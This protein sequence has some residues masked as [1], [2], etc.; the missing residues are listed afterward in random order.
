M[1][2]I[3]ASSAQEQYGGVEGTRTQTMRGVESPAQFQNYFTSPIKIPK[4][5]EIAVESIKIRRDA[6]VDIESQ[7]LFY[8]Y[9]G[10]LQST[11]LIQPGTGQIN[12]FNESRLEMPIPIR[13]SPGTYNTE[14]WL[15]EI[16]SKLNIS[17][18]NPEIFGTYSVAVAPDPTSGKIVGTKISIDQ[19]GDGAGSDIVA[20][21]VGDTMIDQY[22]KSPWNVT[23][24]YTEGT[25]WTAINF[26]SPSPGVQGGKSIVRLAAPDPVDH[27]AD[28]GGFD[29][30]SSMIGN[31]CPFAL[32]NGVFNTNVKSAPNGWRVGLSRPQMEYTIDTRNSEGTKKIG[33]LLPGTRHPQEEGT[34]EAIQGHDFQITYQY[35]MRNSV[36]GRYQKDFY[37]Y[38]VE[39]DGNLVRVYQLSLDNSEVKAN[40]LPD[41]KFVL[42]EVV[43]YGN[44]SSVVA[45]PMTD[46]VFKASYDSVE[47]RS[48]GDEI[49]LWFTSVTKP[50]ND[51]QIV[52]DVRGNLRWNSFLPISECKNALYPRIN[53]KTL[54]DSVLV[55]KYTSHFTHNEVRADAVAPAIIQDYPVFR[56]PTYDAATKTFTTGDDFYTN[57]RVGRFRQGEAGQGANQATIQDI[58]ERPYALSQTLVCDTKDLL[59][60]DQTGVNTSINSYGGLLTLGAGINKNHAFIIGHINPTTRNYYLQGKYATTDSS[61]Q[62][63]MNRSIGFPDRSFIDQI[64]G[65]AQGYVTTADSGSQVVFTSTAPPDYRVHSAFVRIS[66]MP[67][68][69]YNGA[70][71]SVS[72]I[73]YHLPRFTNDGREYGDLFFAPGEKTY[74]KL[75]NPSSEILNN[76]EVQIVDVNERPVSD[77][78]GNTIVVFHLK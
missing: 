69:S 73:L 54:A 23:R 47:F 50:A 53:I 70:K 29:L 52:G 56:Y 17:Y 12:G 46:T 37:D 6:L 4:D 41:D 25:E 14:S 51:T 1:S 78:S 16:E 49:S 60:V 42:S 21:G 22:W 8:K 11:G 28:E 58:R 76:I 26:P 39:N 24:D 55:A 61:G 30:Q 72:K 33:N 15:K 31:G 43:Y 44:A 18:G 10:K 74:V 7:T 48:E 2:L 34:N 64:S 36:G 71:T 19:R 9:F 40:G 3:V 27:P 66:N 65:L 63:K 20:A 75:H 77:I 13:P 62:A 32:V 45:V 5:A 35:N 38:M 68:Q 67:I 57:N 59:V